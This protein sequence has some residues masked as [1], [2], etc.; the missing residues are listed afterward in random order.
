MFILL[1]IYRDHSLE[2]HGA[3]QGGSRI[4][5]IDPTTA[6]KESK[7]VDFARQQHRFTPSNLPLPQPDLLGYFVEC[8]ELH[9]GSYR[10]P[11]VE[12]FKRV[13]QL[14]SFHISA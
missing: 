6:I 1:K 13:E 14:G 10:L 12:L 5:F 2:W 3:E 4:G 9:D 7:S 11:A 8:V